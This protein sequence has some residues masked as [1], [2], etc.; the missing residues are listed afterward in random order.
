MP[1]ATRIRGTLVSAGIWAVVGATAG[2]GLGL[3]FVTP[4]PPLGSDGPRGVQIVAGFGVLFA[5]LG[6]TAGALF[7][8]AVSL[9]GKIRPRVQLSPWKA[10][11]VGAVASALAAAPF[12]DRIG[13]VVSIAA[14]GAALAGG[15]VS[16]ANRS[17]HQTQG[18]HSKAA[19]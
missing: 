12:T 8:A 16:L 14:M 15:L 18:S 9:L 1:L 3:V 19:T 6:A 17:G 11:I 5:L 2:I 4:H 13:N 10:T 7:A